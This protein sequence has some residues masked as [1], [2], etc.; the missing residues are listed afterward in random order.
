MSGGAMEQQ[1]SETE[2]IE[3]LEYLASKNL[4]NSATVSSRKAAAIKMLS[5]IDDD[6]KHDLRKLD[7]EQL[8]QRFT[9]KFGKSFTPESLLTYKSRFN[10]ALNHFL[11]YKESPSTFKIGGSKK[12]SKENGAE[13]KVKGKKLAANLP[14]ATHPQ[15][16]T[17]PKTYILQIPISDG[18]LIEIRNFPMVLT[19]ADATKIAAVI[20]AHAPSL[21]KK[22]Q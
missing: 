7:R 12:A 8:F 10:I 3:F 2:L 15:P 19:E 11:E 9:N 20:K 21:D 1:Y 6:E 4:L 14:N 13:P 5:A 17:E 22:T 18:T 16:V